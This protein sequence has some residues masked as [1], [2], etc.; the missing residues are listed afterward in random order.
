M[1]PREDDES[2]TLGH[3][4]IQKHFL[5]LGEFGTHES[6]KK[7]TKHMRDLTL[8]F[9]YLCTSRWIYIY[10]FIQVIQYAEFSPRA[11]PV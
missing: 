1:L 4:I 10:I 11:L 5:T 6:E 9:V 7:S 2:Q 8:F 3:L